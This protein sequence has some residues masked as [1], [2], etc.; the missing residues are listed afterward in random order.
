MIFKVQYE[1]ISGSRYILRLYGESIAWKAISYYYN[2]MLKFILKTNINDNLE[3][4]LIKRDLLNK[5]E[6]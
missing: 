3:D 4:I 5:L 2:I 6:V 1:I